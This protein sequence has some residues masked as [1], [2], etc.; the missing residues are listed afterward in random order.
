MKIIIAYSP[1]YNY[2]PTNALKYNPRSA[3]IMTK[4][5]ELFPL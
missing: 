2:D 1:I 4:I 5:A 3:F